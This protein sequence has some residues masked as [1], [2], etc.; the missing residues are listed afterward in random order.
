MKPEELIVVTIHSELHFT[1]QKLINVVKLGK[2]SSLF[3]VLLEAGN[4]S[5]VSS[6]AFLTN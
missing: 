1:S 3:A 6:S 4:I 5:S 2:H